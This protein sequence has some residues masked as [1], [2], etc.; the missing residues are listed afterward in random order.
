M[1]HAKTTRG[2]AAVALLLVLTGGAARAATVSFIP[3]GSAYQDELNVGLRFPEG[4]ACTDA[5]AVV[6]ADSGNGRLVRYGYRDGQLSGGSSVTVPQVP[7]PTRVQLDSKGNILVLDR[8]ARRIA[9]LDVAGTFIAF[10]D[11]KGPGGAPAAVGAFKLDGQ[12]NVYVQDLTTNKLLVVAPSGSVIRQLDLPRG[13][14][15]DV[16]VDAAGTLYAVEA[17]GASVWVADRSAKAFKTLATGM[18][19]YLSFPGYVAPSGGRLFVVDQNGHGL[20]I[21]GLDGSYQGRQLALGWN[22]GFLYYPSQVCFTEKGD[23]FV[24]DRSNHRVQVFRTSK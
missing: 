11:V 7:Y 17:G 3:A 9:R 23:A 6:V 21:L 24:A 20:V 5:G 15:T 14:V 19:E 22:E 1:E 16:A 10:L 4:V 8:K 12:D 2:L 13:A 18:R